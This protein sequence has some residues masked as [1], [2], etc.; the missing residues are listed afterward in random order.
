MSESPK[1]KNNRTRKFFLDLSD[2]YDVEECLGDIP[3]VEPKQGDLWSVDRDSEYKVMPMEVL[4]NLLGTSS[5]SEDELEQQRV[6]EFIKKQ[7]SFTGEHFKNKYPGFPD[8]FYD[9]LEEETRLEL[10]PHI[11]LSNNTY[12][13]EKM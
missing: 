7:S 8:R 1:S 11:D 10:K 13:L 4:Q 12:Y 5:L 3:K 2:N 9:L 6:L